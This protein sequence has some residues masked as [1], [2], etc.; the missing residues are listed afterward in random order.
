METTDYYSI[1]ISVA[2]RNKQDAADWARV[3][4]I[5][6]DLIEYRCCSG[7]HYHEEGCE[8]WAMPY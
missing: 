6:N 7:E 5:S 8:N 3:H 1:S 2:F 4:R